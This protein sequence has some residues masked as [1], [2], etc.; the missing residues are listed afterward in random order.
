MNSI[1]YV[2]KAGFSVK[3]ETVPAGLFLL[4]VKYCGKIDTTL[5]MFV[6]DAWSRYHMHNRIIQENKNG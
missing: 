3:G 2:D 4:T 1:L 6:A 5:F